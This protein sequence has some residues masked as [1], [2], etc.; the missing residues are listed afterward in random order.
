MNIISKI[1]KIIIEPFQ[2]IVSFLE[3]KGRDVSLYLS[4]MTVISFIL[5][6]LAEI[7]QTYVNFSLGYS[8][9]G[10]TKYV[11]IKTLEIKDIFWNILPFLI[12]IVL[13]FT[14]HD[15]NKN[16]GCKWDELFISLVS[17]GDII[18]FQVRAL[19]V[20][21][22]LLTIYDIGEFES[23]KTLWN[24]I[25]RNIMSYH[26]FLGLSSVFSIILCLTS[27][28]ILMISMFFIGC[29]YFKK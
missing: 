8:N 3:F 28:F 4:I 9:V 24:I 2:S 1:D 26:Y 5:F 19:Y 20:V 11:G 25:N 12:S 13:S 16:K 27:F 7:I 15:Y 10:Y 22:F 17:K 29:D 18:G 21:I 23:I 6:I 14:I